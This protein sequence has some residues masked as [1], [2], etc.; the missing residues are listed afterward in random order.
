MSTDRARSSERARPTPRRAFVLPFLI[1][2]ALLGALGLA[3]AAVSTLQ[4]PRVTAVD[5][6]PEAAAAASGG[7]L[8]V[9]TSLPLAEVT[10]DQVSIT[11]EVP[12][13]VD[14][15]GRNLGVRFGLPLRDDTEYTITIEGL[16]AAGGGP[17][18]EV[19]E[20]FR[21]PRAEVFL[22]QRGNGGDT[23][24]R[25]DLTGDDAE[26]VFTHPHIED[27]RA[28]S[29]H[30]VMSVLDDDGSAELIVTD[31]D[32]G[33]ERSLPLPGDGFV[34]NLQSAD[35]GEVVGYLYTDEDV[36]AEG[37]QESRLYT[38]SL[39]RG[40]AEVEPTEI[41]IEGAD[42]RIAEW[43]FVPD[44]D[45]ILL[46]SFDGQ[47]LLTGADGADSTA[48]GTALSISGIA[49]GSSEAVVERAD[50]PA[51]IDLTDASEEPLGV[52][53][54]DL[55]TVTTITPMPDGGTI[56]SAAVF[57]SDGSPTG[58]TAVVRVGADG[59]TSALTEIGAEDAVVQTCVSPSARY[60]A[61]LVAPAAA[62]NA[63]DDYRLPLPERLQTRIIEIDDGTQVVSLQ[64]FD[65][66]WC[67]VP[68]R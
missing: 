14:T 45:S 50:G 10:A 56:R 21:T 28:T 57:G 38:A 16:A 51:V 46:L 60:L 49:R 52:P 1:V 54:T 47:L 7:R 26:A 25:T 59:A 67:Q 36:S 9:S 11:P 34:T 35:R 5:V 2:A 55:G 15:S 40:A 18:T 4:G 20:T 39:A 17:A 6:D 13:A 68:P 66:S 3:G 37:A 31:L 19:T 23:V 12:F 53:D 48:L 42:P 29:R 43:R 8:I 62:Q 63:Y 64:G 58:S 22:L 30:L 32:G 27:F 41:A 61:V 33:D 24:F 65:I 44:T